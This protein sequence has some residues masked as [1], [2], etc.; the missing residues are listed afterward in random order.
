MI[1]KVAN[2]CSLENNFSFIKTHGLNLG[3][4]NGPYSWPYA[5]CS[6]KINDKG[7]FIPLEINESYKI[8]L[9]FCKKSNK[10][11]GKNKESKSYD[12]LS[13]NISK[14]CKLQCDTILN[15]LDP[16]NNV[17]EYFKEDYKESKS[18]YISYI[19]ISLFFISL[20]IFN[21]IFNRN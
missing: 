19:L 4:N 8:C 17:K 18:S 3:K 13:G 7:L 5:A 12:K 20:L 6:G 11:T 14:T 2:N 1:K 15:K 21:F 9:D 10:I 16:K